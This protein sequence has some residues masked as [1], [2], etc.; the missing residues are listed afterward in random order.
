MV[1]TTKETPMPEFNLPTPANI[2]SQRKRPGKWDGWVPTFS[3][4]GYRPWADDPGEMSLDDVAHGLAFTYRYGGH[5]DPAITIAEHAVL[6]SNIIR[7]LWPN[8]HLERAA[9]MHD[10]SESP[11]HDIQGPLRGRV[12]VHL[13]DQV[14]TWSAS[15]MLVTANISHPFGIMLEDLQAPEVQA[16]DLLAVCFEK[17]DCKNLHGDWGLP[18]IPEAV[19]LAL[20]MRFHEPKAA[21]AAFLM[22]ADQLGL[23]LN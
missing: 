1:V 12:K 3:G 4:K 23:R 17:R 2:L 9:L 22:R 11:L 15:D 18:S 7:I 21:K 5:S 14:L 20:R 10:A 8:V 6:V 13:D 19:G 16:A